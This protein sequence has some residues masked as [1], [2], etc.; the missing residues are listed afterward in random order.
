MDNYISIKPENICK[1]IAT[2]SD[3][4]H[5]CREFGQRQPFE[6]EV[7][8][9]AYK[10]MPR[11]GNKK[12]TLNDVLR[13]YSDPANFNVPHYVMLYINAQGHNTF[14]CSCCGAAYKFA[15]VRDVLSHASTTKHRNNAYSSFVKST[16]TQ[17]MMIPIQMPFIFQ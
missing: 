2:M 11:T 9:F 12:F 3:K 1:T 15:K 13:F 16:T 8:T 14:Y 6:C 17:M 4:I 5:V 7:Y 10:N